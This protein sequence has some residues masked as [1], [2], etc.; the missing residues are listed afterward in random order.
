MT[1]LWE[2]YLPLKKLYTV[3]NNYLQLN[4]NYLSLMKI[5]AVNKII[6]C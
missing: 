1:C 2:K 6:Y 3:N 5:F 4:N